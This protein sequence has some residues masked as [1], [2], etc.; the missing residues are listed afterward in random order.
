ME[1]LGERP[2]GLRRRQQVYA[3]QG[4]NAA[5][6]LA[7]A[8]LLADASPAAH[9]LLPALLG[10]PPPVAL[11]DAPAAAPTLSQVHIKSCR[12][13]RTGAQPSCT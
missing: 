1:L 13:Q 2:R 9:P 8:A 4:P 10:C 6:Q 3:V 11:G 7:A 12:L 5:T